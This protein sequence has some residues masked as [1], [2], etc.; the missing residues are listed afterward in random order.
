[1]TE[2]PVALVAEVA[3][4]LG[5]LLDRVVFIGGAIAPLLQPDRPF[6]APRPTTDVDAIAATA[7]YVDFTG[8]SDELRALGFREV[9]GSRHAHRWITPSV[10]AV[11]FDLVPAGNHIGASGNRWDK[12]AI[13]TAITTEIEPGL[14]I[15]HVSAPGFLALKL[16][17]FRDRGTDDPFGSSDLEDI[18]A[19]VAARPA[20]VQEVKE[21]REDLRR[22]V[23]EQ[24][25]DL[26]RRG[27]FEDLLAGHLANVSRS[28]A[29]E[30]IPATQARLAEIAD[31]EAS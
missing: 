30:I 23:C 9:S 10:H 2:G 1:M 11:S 20:I 3:R 24:V 31:A 18:L 17:A 5:H 6:R 15:R 21:E 8:L 16:A 7:S 14:T 13:E 25:G 29:V 27:D 22:F 26:R 12:V 19:L 28:R 4:A